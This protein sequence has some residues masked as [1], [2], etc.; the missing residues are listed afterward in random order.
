MSVALTQYLQFFLSLVA[1]RR[2]ETKPNQTNPIQSNDD[3]MCVRARVRRPGYDADVIGVVK[4]HRAFDSM[5]PRFSGVIVRCD[6]ICVNSMT[7]RP[8]IASSAFG[9]S[10]GRSVEIEIG[11]GVGVGVRAG[12]CVRLFQPGPVIW[13]SSS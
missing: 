13:T 4:L 2:V 12:V 3:T 8:E 9:R 5:H 11:V 1:S 6:H 10:V 7:Y